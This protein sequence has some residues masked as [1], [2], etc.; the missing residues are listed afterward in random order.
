MTKL[1]DAGMLMICLGIAGRKAIG[2]L[3][4]Q[5]DVLRHWT[6]RT[7][8]PKSGPA[9][10]IKNWTPGMTHC[11]QGREPGLDSRT[12]TQ[13]RGLLWDPDSSNGSMRWWWWR[14]SDAVFETFSF[15]SE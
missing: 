1:K 4:S 15:P 7:E 6:N 5:Y 13:P 2:L 14:V 12:P 8:V 10:L 11:C 9:N 3:G